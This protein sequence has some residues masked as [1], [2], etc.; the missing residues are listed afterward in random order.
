MRGQSRAAA[1]SCSRR[2]SGSPWQATGIR[3]KS[4][5]I[6]RLVYFWQCTGSSLSIFKIKSPMKRSSRLP[7]PI[8]VFYTE[9]YWMRRNR[10]SSCLSPDIS[11]SSASQ[12]G[13]SSCRGCPVV[14]FPRQ[15]VLFIFSRNTLYTAFHAAHSPSNSAVIV[16]DSVFATGSLSRL[17]FLRRRI[18]PDY[19][20]PQKSSNWVITYHKHFE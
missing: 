16:S 10:R 1:W 13:P 3:S 18:R 6:F 8:F 9:G 2:S 4:V 5:I 17:S 15:R 19:R 20:S 7:W 11:C 14:I 12:G